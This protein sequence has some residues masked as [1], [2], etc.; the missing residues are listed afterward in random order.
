MG[1]KGSEEE[2][3]AKRG[4]RKTAGVLDFSCAV[5]AVSVWDLETR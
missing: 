4:K 5:G 3:K 2:Q 1:L